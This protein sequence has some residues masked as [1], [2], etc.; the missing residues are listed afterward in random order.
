MIRDKFKVKCVMLL[1]IEKDY[2]NI[3]IGNLYDAYFHPERS[4]YYLIK[5]NN[6]VLTYRPACNFEPIDILEAQRV[7]ELHEK[8]LQ[9]WRSIKKVICVTKE[10]NGR[11]Y[12]GGVIIGEI[13]DVIEYIAN[14]A[15]NGRFRIKGKL[16][17]TSDLFP[18]ELFI[19]LEQHR[20][21][22]LEK[23]LN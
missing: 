6:G 10:Y 14:N 15:P 9:Y 18:K 16:D 19:T 1:G 8:D 7:K 4:D 20:Q 11:T 17:G 23:I 2:T 21:N 3:T 12:K 22:Q 5:D 13:Y